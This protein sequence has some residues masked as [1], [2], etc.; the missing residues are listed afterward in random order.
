MTGVK[1][2]PPIQLR[3]DYDSRHLRYVLPKGASEFQGLL[4]GAVATDR[5]VR[6]RVAWT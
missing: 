1:F 6:V 5:N 4:D 3:V 2:Q